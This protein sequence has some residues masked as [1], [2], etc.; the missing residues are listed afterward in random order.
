MVALNVII[1]GSPMRKCCN[2][3]FRLAVEE[4]LLT[5]KQYKIRTV[6]ELEGILNFVVK[7]LKEEEKKNDSNS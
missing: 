5:I 4:I 6:I 1:R 2:I 3:T 7:V